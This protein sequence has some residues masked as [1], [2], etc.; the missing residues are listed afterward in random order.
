MPRVDQWLVQGT[1]NS[2]YV[3]VF[4]PQG[5]R[6]VFGHASVHTIITHKDIEALIKGG[7]ETQI[8]EEYLEAWRTLW[9]TFRQDSC[10]L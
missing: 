6:M 8:R 9:H 1:V 3:T 7:R 4:N 5:W 10:D 2:E